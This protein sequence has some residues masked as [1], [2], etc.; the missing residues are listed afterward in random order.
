M[1]QKCR[2]RGKQEEKKGKQKKY[3]WSCRDENNIFQK[4]PKQHK[5][6]SIEKV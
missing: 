1:K 4:S 5:I 6:L 3:K 2:E